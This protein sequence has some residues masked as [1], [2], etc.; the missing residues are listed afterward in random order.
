M[1]LRAL[2]G[3]FPEQH[4]FVKVSEIITDLT[5]PP[6][7]AVTD[8]VA[9][10]AAVVLPAVIVRLVPCPGVMVVAESFAVTPAG[11]PLTESESGEAK[12][13][14]ADDVS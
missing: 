1:W 3:Y 8:T 4:Y 9:E 7:D 6:P 12:P 13:Y 11:A 5:S 2:A 14:C 10:A